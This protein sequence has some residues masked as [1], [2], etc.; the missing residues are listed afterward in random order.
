MAKKKAEVFELD[1][2]NILSLAKDLSNEFKDDGVICT[3]DSGEMGGEVPY[4]VP[5]SSTL[6]NAAIGGVGKGIPGGRIIEI[7]G[8]SSTG[9]SVLC[10]DIISNAQKMGGIGMYID[11]E[12][13]TEKNFAGVLGIDAKKLVSTQ[14]RTVEELYNKAMSFIEKARAKFGMDIP[15][16]IVGDSVTAPTEDE[17]E[18]DMRESMK[19]G[20]SAKTQRR[21]LRK[22]VSMVSD[23]Q[24]IFIGINHL[25]ANIGGYIKDTPTG[26]SGWDFYP[27]L[28]IRLSNPMKIEGVVKDSTIGIITKAYIAKSKLDRPFRSADI[29]L[30]YSHGIDDI[31]PTLEFVR[32]NSTLFGT[33]SGWYKLPDGTSYRSK[34]MLE[35]MRTSPDAF[36]W[37][38]K[39][40]T[41]MLQ[42]GT[43][44]G[45]EP[46]AGPKPAESDLSSISEEELFDY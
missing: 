12:G 8:K 43:S 28:R 40:A 36:E 7:H 25:T 23:Q 11:T 18:K 32:Q 30:V 15:I 10:Y 27:S 38:K 22:L 39:A 31:T 13:S 33:S 29:H 14:A 41:Q 35:L 37:L 24:V 42:T 20:D 34:E 1:E 45:I 16:V 17:F 2:A 26:G 21:A 44:E 3:L 9:K 6:L 46:Y 4:W 5:T 19:L